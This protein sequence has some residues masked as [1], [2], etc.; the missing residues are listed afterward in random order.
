MVEL[1]D[2]MDSLRV[3]GRG[4]RDI[5][6]APRPSR[7]NVETS[8]MVLFVR[9]RGYAVLKPGEWWVELDEL[10]CPSEGLSSL[11]QLIWTCSVKRFRILKRLDKVPPAPTSFRS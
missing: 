3:P 6:V 4:D 5:G 11:A 1:D 2:E 10:P 8:E 9:K 7:S